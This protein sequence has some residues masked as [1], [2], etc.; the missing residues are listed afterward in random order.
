[1]IVHDLNYRLDG[2]LFIDLAFNKIKTVYDT[3]GGNTTATT[4]TKLTT[5]PTAVP[6][7]A[8]S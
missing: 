1:M 6:T 7:Y 3:L 8:N 5:Q 4:T 2:R